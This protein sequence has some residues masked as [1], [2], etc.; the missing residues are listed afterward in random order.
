VPA[1][2][3][4]PASTLAPA[5]LRMVQGAGG[6]ATILARGSEW[7]GAM[8][9]V[10]RSGADVRVYEK[11]PAPDGED[12]WRA[13]ASGEAAVDSFVARQRRFD[14]DLWVIELD[15][16]ALERFVPGFGPRD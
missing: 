3:P 11:L 15:I 4:L 16:P 5:L 13:A 9:I 7:G 14:P 8:L 1:E 6:F 12:A 2:P 10:H